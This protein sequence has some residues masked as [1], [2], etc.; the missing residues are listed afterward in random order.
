MDH[1]LQS[2]VS[3]AVQSAMASSGE[4][5][6]KVRKNQALLG[7]GGLGVVL[8][9]IGYFESG[10]SKHLD[11]IS[12]ELTQ[13]RLQVALNAK[14]E[15]EVRDLEDE[16]DELVSKSDLEQIH[17][18]LEHRLKMLEEDVEELAKGPE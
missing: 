13:I 11:T 7:S 2:T 17:R 9:V 16:I 4:E 18:L 10:Q 6:R 1:D 12:A 5:Q 3:E 15:A 14:L 8:A